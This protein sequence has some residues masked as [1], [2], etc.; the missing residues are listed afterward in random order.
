MPPPMSSSSTRG[1][2]ASITASLSETLEPPSTTT[3]G[4]SGEPGHDDDLGAGGE[5]RAQRRQHRPDPAVIRDRLA[6]QRHVQVGA[7]E[8]APTRDALGEEVVERFHSVAPT[9]A[10]RSTRRLE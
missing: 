3:Y 10:T 4:R 5:Q 1:A 7:H 8:H 2:S 6:V 9:N